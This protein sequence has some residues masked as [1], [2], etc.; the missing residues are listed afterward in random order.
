MRMPTIETLRRL[1]GALDVATDYLLGLIDIPGMVEADEFVGLD[2]N[3]LS[4][5]DRELARKIFRMLVK[6]SQ[7]TRASGEKLTLI[8][9][10]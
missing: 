6:R 1:G 4:N 8:S 7:A 2:I 9:S 5:N 10:V 3:R